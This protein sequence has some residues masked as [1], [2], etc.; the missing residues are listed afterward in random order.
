[1]GWFLSL[2]TGPLLKIIP[3]IFKALSSEQIAKFQAESGL[4]IAEA[5]ALAQAETARLA[6][7]SNV[8]MAAMTHPIWWVAWVLF[9]FPVGLY[10]AANY[11]KSVGCMFAE[12]YHTCNA[13]WQILQV[14]PTLESWGFY[15]VMSMF[16][17]SVASSV[18]SKIASSIG[19]LPG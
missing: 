18:V 13:A 1:M 19:R 10:M 6:A 3:G 7:Q 4:G 16:S 5:T 2:F 12:N 17:L 15:V 9:V 11:L 14:P 8:Q